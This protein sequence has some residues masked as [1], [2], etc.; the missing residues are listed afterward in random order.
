VDQRV[1]ERHRLDQVRRELLD[2]QPALLQR[3]RHQAEV[4]HLQVAQAAV[5]ELA[6]AAGGPG[7]EVAGLDEADAQPAG[8]R[9]E[10]APGADDARNES[11]STSSNGG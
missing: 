9:V 3:L 8:G 10:R 5:D 4:E 11:R 7:G 2:Q 6:G 1:D